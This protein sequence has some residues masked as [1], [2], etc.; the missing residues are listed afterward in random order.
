MGAKLLNQIKEAYGQDVTI[1]SI[2]ILG[3]D[4]WY[5]ILKLGMDEATV[6]SARTE[7]PVPGRVWTVWCAG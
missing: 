6:K 4:R 2:P 7:V 3:R 1:Q 5:V